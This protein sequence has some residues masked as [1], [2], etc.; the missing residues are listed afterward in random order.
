MT[1]KER[2]QYMKRVRF[3]PSPTG[4]LHVGNVRAALINYLFAKKYDAE[5][6]LR[7]DDTDL[8]RSKQEYV[9][10]LKEDLAW[11][12]IQHNQTFRQ[13]D[14]L[15][16]YNELK[17]LLIKEGHLY[18]CYETE[19]ELEV[20]RKIQLSCGKPPVYIP[21]DQEDMERFLK[22]GRKPHYRFRLPNVEVRWNDLVKGD[23]HFA[24]QTMSDPILVREDGSYLY[25]YTS[26][27][28]DV[29]YDITHIFRGQDH[30]SNTAAQILIFKVVCALLGKEF[31]IDFGHTSFLLGAQ[32]E[33]LSKRVGSIS[34]RD[35]REN[36]IHPMSVVSYLFYSGT[37][38]ATE[39][40]HTI[41]ELLEQFDVKNYGGASPKFSVDELKLLN[42]K[43]Y[44][45]ASFE[46]VSSL[47]KTTMTPEQWEVIRFN[48]EKSSD[49]KDWENILDDHFQASFV[50]KEYAASILALLPKSL[51]WKTW[52][53]LIKTTTG[54]KG[55]DAVMPI[56][57]M[58][59]GKEHGPE[60][61]Q[62]L[63]MLGQEKVVKRLA[64][65]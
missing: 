25:T 45:T 44:H 22:E 49:I 60:M 38:N 12:G 7:I 11:L 18:P 50:D 46:W 23:M 28:D 2:I 48:V 63:S 10:A 47:L 8:K 32:G 43:L 27:I 17:D 61:Q 59:T 54:R 24:K 29:D 26:V 15:D 4:Y 13:S 62:L 52:F 57:L 6:F 3:A 40:K 39:P 36:D 37:P 42:A 34:I 21:S 1:L 53:E 64:S 33:P 14:R 35:L 19:E 16:R 58:L 55:K 56:R 30:V 31:K 41:E 9:D 20:R 5:F 51:D 65:S